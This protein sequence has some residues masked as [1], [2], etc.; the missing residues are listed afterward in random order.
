L[1]PFKSYFGSL[2]LLEST[3]DYWNYIFH[4]EIPFLD[5]KMPSFIVWFHYLISEGEFVNI[6]QMDSGDIANFIQPQFKHIF[7][8]VYYIT[9]LQK[10]KKKTHP[11]CRIVTSDHMN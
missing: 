11:Q 2:E 9:V 7:S 6:N 10:K 3:L 4:S 5:S 8:R 1:N